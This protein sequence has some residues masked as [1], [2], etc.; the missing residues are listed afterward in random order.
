VSIFISSLRV[1]ELVWREGVLIKE[2][3]P[4]AYTIKNIDDAFA[5]LKTDDGQKRLE[6]LKQGVTKRCRLFWLTNSALVYESKC[7]RRG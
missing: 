2:F 4:E 3:P 7:G 5:F 1:A 6:L